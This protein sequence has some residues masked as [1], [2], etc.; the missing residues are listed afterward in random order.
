[1]RA[2]VD[3][4]VEDFAAAD[5]A[6]G[7]ATEIL[8]LSTPELIRRGMNAIYR[9]DDVVL[10][11]ATPNAAASVSLDLAAMLRKEGVPVARPASSEVIEHRG[12]AVT[13]WE[14]VVAT[15]EPIDW[16]A[17]GA[18]VRSVHEI[19]LDRVPPGVPTPSPTDFPWWDHDALLADVVDLLDVDARR[20]LADAIDRHRGW[21]EWAPSDEVLCHG[22]VHPGNV[23][24]AAEGPVL[25]DWDLLCRAPR[26]WDHGPMMSWTERWGGAP[27]V[28]DAMAQ[29]AGWSAR[30]DRF[31]ESVAELRLVSATL[32]RLKVSRHLPAA[33]AESIRRLEYWRG[34]PVP[35]IWNAQ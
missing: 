24:M 34:D 6:A 11:V 13:A 2:Y 27:G 3:Q 16:R 7:A 30:G 1:M 31:G 19:P 22:D 10:R 5:S 33:R 4:R 32:M 15:G 14:Y 18:I 35:A 9:C 26:G 25:V 29:G 8:G 17:V 28:Y 12:H 21:R 20:G 23:I